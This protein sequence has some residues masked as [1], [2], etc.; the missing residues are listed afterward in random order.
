MEDKITV[1]YICSDYNNCF[2][3]YYY[4]IVLKNGNNKVIA[5]MDCPKGYSNTYEDIFNL[6]MEKGSLALKPDEGSHGA[7]SYTH[8][9]VYKRQWVG[10]GFGI[11]RLTMAIEK[12]KT[13]KRYGR[14]IA[15]I[16]G[17][18]LNI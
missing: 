5:M 16:D 4:H 12:S 17:Q 9:D 11:E 2:P 8:L 15:F 6:A 7:V 13:I 18:P 14:S 1:K 10:I 3:E